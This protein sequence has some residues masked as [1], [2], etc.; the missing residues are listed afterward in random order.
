MI[1][2]IL[3]LR[4]T[5]G[6]TPNKPL[7][8]L[9]Q[10]DDIYTGLSGNPTLFPNCNPTA[11]VLLGQIQDAKTAQQ[12][13]GKIKGASAVR[14][15]KFKIVVTSLESERMMVQWLCDATPDQAASLIAA[16]RMTSVTIPARQ[17]PLLGARNGPS[18]TVLLEA[19]A[20]LLDGTHRRKT[21]N[22]RM[23]TDGEKTFTGLPSTPVGKTTVSGL[24]PLT[25]YYFRF[26]ATT[27]KGSGAYSQVVSLLVL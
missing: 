21:F 17:K 6:L 14:D 10:A 26:R 15:A 18:G 22:W 9:A 25:T 20:S 27:R 1:G 19:N 13:V 3:R 23:T 16:A 2:R 5:L 4:V 7:V 12:N 11:P 24:T 8:F